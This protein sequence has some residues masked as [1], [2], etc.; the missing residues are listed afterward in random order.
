MAL[1]ADN[2]IAFLIRVL[3]REFFRARSRSW[4]KTEANVRSAQAKENT[5]YPCAEISYTYKVTFER[6]QG[7]YKR[8]FWY[9]DSAQEFAR[10]FV[11]NEYVTIRVRPEHPEQSY[12]FEED[13]S[14]WDAWTGVTL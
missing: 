9:R 12:V 8:G 1:I 5:M 13:Q 10:L 14:W 11:P 3:M 4:R 6:Y 7:K 2:I